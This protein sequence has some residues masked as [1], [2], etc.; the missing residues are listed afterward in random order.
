MKKIFIYAGV[1]IIITLLI[2][3]NYFSTD[4]FIHVIWPLFIVPA[5]LLII[6]HPYWKVA[7]FLGI[8]MSGLKFSI[9]LARHGLTLPDA[10]WMEMVIGALVNWIILFSLTYL[11]IKHLHA[12]KESQQLS[13]E[14]KDQNAFL[15]AVLDN[16]EE[17]VITCD[18]DGK[19]NYLNYAAKP[20]KNL[21][22][23]SPEQWEQYYTFYAKDGK[24][25]IDYMEL[26]LYLAARGQEV[27]QYEIWIE[28]KGSGNKQNIVVNGRPLINIDGQ[29]L[30]AVVV[31]HDMTR[32]KQMEQ[33]ISRTKEQYESLFQHNFDAVYS[34]DLEGNFI[35]SNPACEQL[36]GFSNEEMKTQSFH[37][38][39]VV[40]DLQKTMQHFEEAKK[41]MSQNYE[42]T[43]INKNRERIIV[44]VSNVP[45]VVDGEVV[46]LFGIAKNITE[47]KKHEEKIQYMA[48]Y[49]HLTGLPNRTLFRDRTLQ[50][51]KHAR[52]E[53]STMAVMFLDLDGFKLV[54]DT[55]GHNVGD[56]LLKEVTVRFHGCLDSDHTLAR[57]GGDEFTILLP[58]I[59]QEEA[60]D[61][62]VRLKNSLKEPFVFEEL[63]F[64]LSVSIGIAYYD[65]DEDISL[66]TLI[67]QADTAM[68]YIKGKG[69]DGFSIYT[70]EMDTKAL[71]KVMLENDL[72]TALK[73][74]EFI[75]EYQPIVEI[76][77][78]KIVAMESLVRWN[79]QQLGRIAPSE[80]IGLAEDT[81]LIIPLGEWILRKACAQCKHWQ[82]KGLPPIKVSVNVSVIQLRQRE[83]FLAT[84]ENILDETGLEAKWL[85]LEITET[86]LMEN[87]EEFISIL[88]QIRNMGISISIDDFGTG[89]S[90]MSHMKNFAVNTI[91]IDRSFIRDLHSDKTSAAIVK[92][93]ITLAEHLQL[94]TIA[95][96]IENEEQ[97]QAVFKEK[98]REM[99]GYYYSPP[100]PPEQMEQYLRKGE[101]SVT[102]IS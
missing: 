58:K 100:V 15:E 39:I 70:E 9:L 50:A 30:G 53:K 87:E 37:S 82:E 14:M 25:V 83:K 57:M 61:I 18:V 93:I 2:F 73:N 19:I 31:F 75:L 17:F 56:Q 41:G 72:R 51:W 92:S 22:G 38:F 28:T 79:H 64:H 4:Q 21:E 69:K 63:P 7:I 66:N 101:N 8:C 90:S 29:S 86:V 43:I 13:K 44:N 35:T 34:M 99:Q 52:K 74:E 85:D 6:I 81:R 47:Q 76:E 5:I 24:T 11:L 49:D 32:R 10:V 60:V 95:E 80:F 96:G 77:S 84:I 23:A 33:E 36:T 48:Y 62:A 59:N 54:N 12:T 102:S 65:G 88:Q 26:P 97:L 20:F 16:M 94:N 98:C 71:R 42:V 27:N 55:L 91:K 40:E 46:G 45:M 3:I 78:G 1:V 67:R 89:Y 68:Y